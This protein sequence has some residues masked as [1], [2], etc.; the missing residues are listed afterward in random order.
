MS[1][2]YPRWTNLDFLDF[3]HPRIRE[4][5]DYW[6]GKRGD[7]LMPRRADIEPLDLP[8]FL[9][10]IVMVDIGYQP[11][12]SPTAWSAGAKRKRADTIPPARACST[13]G[14]A[15]RRRM[16]WRITGW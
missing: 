3:C 5:Y 1:S 6:N 7:R 2:R 16:C 10:G 15:A 11:T 14:T 12:P 13:I 8:S 4:I 9:P